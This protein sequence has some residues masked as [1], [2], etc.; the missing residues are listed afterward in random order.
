MCND[1]MLHTIAKLKS[2]SDEEMSMFLAL[3]NNECAAQVVAGLRCMPKQFRIDLT[4]LFD[5]R[6]KNYV[7]FNCPTCRSEQYVIAE[8][9]ESGRCTQCVHEPYPG[10]YELDWGD[11]VDFNVRREYRCEHCEGKLADTITELQEVIA[12]AKDGYVTLK[13][14]KTTNEE[15]GILGK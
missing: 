5:F 12:A 7:K 2:C 15:L 6:D 13:S 8:V 11:T 3:L 9:V 1:S 14:E 4:A 10:Y